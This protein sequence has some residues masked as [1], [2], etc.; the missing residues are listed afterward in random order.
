MLAIIAGWL[1]MLGWLT[2][3]MGLAAINTEAWPT[4]KL[5]TSMLCILGGIGCLTAKWHEGIEWATGLAIVMI[6]A[7]VVG[8]FA[9]GGVIASGDTEVKTIHPGMPS[10]ATLVA[11][12]LLGVMR[13]A[14]NDPNRY[15]ITTAMEAIG[16]LAIVGYAIKQP[17]MYY[18]L[19]SLSTGMALTTAIAV[20]ATGRSVRLENP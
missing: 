3:W 4:M 14:V 5:S 18:Y 13:L 2:G 6:I 10:W 11:F 1:G 8:A 12:F 15:R 20:V 9:V 16:L 17:W 7:S 19:P